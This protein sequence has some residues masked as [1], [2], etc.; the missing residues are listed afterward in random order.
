MKFSD[1]FRDDGNAS[2]M[3]LGFFVGG[4]VI[5]CGGSMGLAFLDVCMYQGTHLSAI[6]GLAVGL[7]GVIVTGK[8]IQSFSEPAAT[9]PAA[10]ADPKIPK[11]V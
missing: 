9:P 11:G 3:R 10:P 1:F 7:V 2:M 6:T 8:A 5:G 4:I